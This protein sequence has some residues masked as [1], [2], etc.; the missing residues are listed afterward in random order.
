MTPTIHAHAQAAGFAV[1]GLESPKPACYT[2]AST[3]DTHTF[4]PGRRS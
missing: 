4:C 1:I 3:N 2:H